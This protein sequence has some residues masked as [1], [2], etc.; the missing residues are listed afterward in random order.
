MYRGKTITIKAFCALMLLLILQQSYGQSLS[1][2]ETLNMA[3]RA[4]QLDKN[5][6]QSMM[7][8]IA[9]R[10][11]GL[12]QQAI[13]QWNEA[14]ALY[15]QVLSKGTIDSRGSR[16]AGSLM[17]FVYDSK[18]MLIGNYLSAYGDYFAN[19]L[20]KEKEEEEE[21]TK[22]VSFEGGE[23]KLSKKYKKNFDSLESSL[24]KRK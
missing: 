24:K 23:Y 14:L 4:D 2:S 10:E 3:S 15:N 7:G 17:A 21:R 9:K 8:F 19:E 6:A 20:L 22:K 16:M 12:Q 13:S 18:K 1:P 5:A 11:I